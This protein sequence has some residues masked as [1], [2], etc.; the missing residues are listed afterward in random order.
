MVVASIAS[1][2]RFARCVFRCRTVLAKMRAGDGNGEIA[3]GGKLAMEDS[4]QRSSLRNANE[5][6]V[7]VDERTRNIEHR[8][9][10]TSSDLRNFVDHVSETYATKS[11]LAPIKSVVYG[12]VALILVAVITAVVSKVVAL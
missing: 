1:D 11:D 10:A 4:S 8:I 9:A 6:L 7:R 3:T 2:G 12:L 5:L